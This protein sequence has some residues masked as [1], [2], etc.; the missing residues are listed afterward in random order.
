MKLIRLVVVSMLAANAVWAGAQ[1]MKPGLWEITTTMQ[2]GSGEMTDAMTRAQKQ[3]ESMPPEQRKKMESL[4]AQKGIQMG[5]GAGGMTI[6]V[7]MTQEMVDRNQV[8]GPHGDC[9]QTSSPRIGG[10]MKF[11]YVCTKPPSSGEGQITV[12]SPEAYSMKMSTT[13]TVRGQPQKMEMQ[14]SGRRLDKDCGS[15]KPLNMSGK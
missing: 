10:T 9:T 11:S 1:T 6:K 8:S 7:C 15:V 12:A 5:S 2:N 3:I 4:M 13:S 14:S